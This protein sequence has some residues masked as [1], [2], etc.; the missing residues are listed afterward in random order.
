M[1][2]YKDRTIEVHNVFSNTSK[3]DKDLN[4]LKEGSLANAVVLCCPP[5]FLD[6]S[7]YGTVTDG[8]SGM[9]KE[10][11]KNKNNQDYGYHYAIS[12]K[13]DEKQFENKYKTDEYEYCI[14]RRIMK[15]Y[16]GEVNGFA[17]IKDKNG[18][19]VEPEKVCI[20]VLLLPP[21]KNF[22]AYEFRT[23]MEVASLLHEN[24]LTINDLYRS[25]DIK[26]ETYGPFYMLD[27]DIWN[28]YKD[29]VDKFLSFLNANEDKDK[30][31]L[32]SYINEQFK[33]DE[34]Y[35]DGTCLTKIYNDVEI[36]MPAYESPFKEAAKAYTDDNKWQ[37]IDSIIDEYVSKIF[38]DHTTDEQIQDYVNGFIQESNTN[39]GQ[40]IEGSLQS[41]EQPTKNKLQYRINKITPFNDCKCMK[42]TDQLQAEEKSE[43]LKTE[44]IYPDL[45]T[46]PGGSISVADGESIS[47]VQSQSNTALTIEEFEKRQHTFNIAD[48]DNISKNTTGRPINCED[49]FPV[50]EQIKKLQ[51]HGPKVK[52][53]KIT[54]D[55]TEDNHLRSPLGKTLAK[56]LNMIYDI[57]TEQAKRTEKRLVLIENNLATVMRNLFRLSSRININCVYYGGQ[58]VYGKYKCIRCLKD[59]RINDGAIVTLD[60]CLCCTRYEPIEGQVYA[61]LDET[62]SNVSQVIDDIQMS[63]MSLEQ[64][65][66]LNR[67]EQMYTEMNNAN[68]KADSEDIPKQF[69]DDKWKDTDKEQEEKKKSDV[70]VTDEDEN[71]AGNDETDS[72]YEH[73]EK[74]ETAKDKTYKNGFEMKWD[75]VLLETQKENVNEYELENKEL[76]KTITSEEKRKIGRA[77][78]KD[79]REKN[80]QY[81]VLE[82]NIKNYEINGFGNSTEIGSGVIG[83]A[84]EVRNKIVAYAQNAVKL[85]QEG[86][87]G[88]SMGNRHNHDDKAING[89]HYWDCSSLAESA[90]AAAGITGIGSTTVDEYSF[91][92]RSAGGKLI[93]LANISEALPGDMVWFCRDGKAYNTEDDMQNVPYTNDSLLHHVAIYVGNNEFI[94]AQ[95][96]KRGIVQSSIE[97]RDVIGFGRPKALIDADAAASASSCGQVKLDD[98]RLE[99]IAQGFEQEL[100]VFTSQGKTTP[101][102]GAGAYICQSAKKHNLSPL[103]CMGILGQESGFGTDGSNVSINNPFNIRKGAKGSTGEKNGWSVFPSIKEGIDAW[104]DLLSRYPQNFG[105]DMTNCY[106]VEQYYCPASDGNTPRKWSSGV[107]YFA[108]KIADL[109]GVDVDI[110]RGCEPLSGYEC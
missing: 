7:A 107:Y 67:N 9:L 23:I 38:K 51:K 101:L 28:K 32:Y 12:S 31:D 76:N 25:F 33:D 36:K 4:L 75:D 13:C 35:I 63:Y 84:T 58:S 30:S 40:V 39:G 66:T 45:I 46:P 42:A 85:Q 57:C 54:Y 20:S 64:Y 62:G 50:D 103:F 14:P 34:H 81:E 83:N 100:L 11:D 19:K 80:N 27:T 110:Q 98:A 95:G 73:I 96:R 89:K 16:E 5:N 26:K 90:Y 102:T 29:L 94:E 44:P 49:E 104:T 10:I 48:F 78:F 22:V 93:P 92:L 99:K 1:I 60:Q 21:S 72:V 88:Y 70:V 37:Q 106:S 108:K 47:S 68:L 97:G 53:D 24:K 77:E 74:S 59:N 3:T 56:N 91:D 17:E 61:I 82:Y 55:F 41:K 71:K 18:N 2:S 52:I 6:Q 43:E 69:I 8:K 79:S 65:Q 86:K 87:A 109:A 105:C 15:F